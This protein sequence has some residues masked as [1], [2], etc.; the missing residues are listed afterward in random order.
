MENILFHAHQEP[1]GQK[2]NKYQI[3][4][5][6]SFLTDQFYE[7]ESAQDRIWI[8]TMAL[9]AGHFSN[10]LARK[11]I[12]AKSRGVPDI[13][14][15]YDAFSDYVTDNTFNHLPLPKKEDREFKSF[16]L[17]QNKELVDILKS[18]FKVT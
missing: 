10:L 16:L 4:E 3:L 18:H 5:G 12:M 6:A 11:L 14:L 17:G 1:K 8:Q 2:T 7:I 9:E 13:R 15:V